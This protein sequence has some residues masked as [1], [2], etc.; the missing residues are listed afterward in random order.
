LTCTAASRS[1]IVVGSRDAPARSS[2][3]V[4]ATPH[5]VAAL[6]RRWGASRG[7]STTWKTRFGNRHRLPLVTG[8]A[9][10]TDQ[11]LLISQER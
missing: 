3:C 8:K 5:P 7:E 9:L 10:V 4:A 11:V 2:T 1:C 6:H